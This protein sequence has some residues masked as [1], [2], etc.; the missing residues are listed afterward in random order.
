MSMLCAVFMPTR[1]SVLAASSCCFTI[2][3]AALMNLNVKLALI[4][5]IVVPIILATSTWFFKRISKAYEAYQEQ[6]ATLS[7]TLQENLTGVRV[8]KAFARQDYEIKKFD[9]DN[10][11]KYQ[12]GKRLVRMHALFWPV[13]DTICGFQLVLGY[14]IGATMAINGEISVGTYLAYAGLIIWIIFP[15][16]NLGRLIVQLSTGQVSFGRV[17]EIIKQDREPLDQGNYQPE[18]SIQGGLAFDQVGFEYEP[19]SPVLENISFSIQP[20]HSR[21]VVGLHRIGQNIAG[22]PAAAF[23]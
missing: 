7:T 17:M 3:F 12:R 8:V 2:N 10:W 22:Q 11:E 15:M 19:G 18:G 5:I 21:G 13:S 1:P 6:E 20:G 14:F 23:L 4:S 9:T 16:R